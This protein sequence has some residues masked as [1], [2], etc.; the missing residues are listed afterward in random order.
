MANKQ[1]TDFLTAENALDGNEPVY[2]AQGGKTR[3]TLLSKIKDFIIGTTNMGTTATDVTGA[4][5]EI[6]GSV[7]SNTSQL[8]DMANNIS[9]LQNNKEDKIS[10]SGWLTLSLESGVLPY[11]EYCTPIYRKIGKTVEIIGVITNVKNFNTATNVTYATLPSGFRCKK[12][13]TVLCQGSTK[14]TWILTVD[15]GGYLMGSRYGNGQYKETM[16][17]KEWLPFHVVYTVD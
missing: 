10:D 11:N 1:L 7:D 16:D 9:I 13:F 5:A 8:N 3:K 15:A 14:D 12:D 4:I 17:G 6:K 2:I